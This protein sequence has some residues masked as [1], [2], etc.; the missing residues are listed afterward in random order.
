MTT[1]KNSRRRPFLAEDRRNI[2]PSDTLLP[3]HSFPLMGW[4]NVPH[5]RKE[6]RRNEWYMCSITEESLR[7]NISVGKRKKKLDGRLSKE[8]EM[9]REDKKA[10]DIFDWCKIPVGIGSVVVA[11]QRAIFR[12][13][14]LY[15]LDYRLMSAQKKALM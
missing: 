8:K 10:K 4:K 7:K 9:I 13:S 15:R 14:C 6:L 3:P 11:F 1:Q 2:E 5:C 12:R